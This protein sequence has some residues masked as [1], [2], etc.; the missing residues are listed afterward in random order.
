MG[1]ERLTDEPRTQI[2][3]TDA[4]VDHIGKALVRIAR[5]RATMDALNQRS[6]PGKCFL[7]FF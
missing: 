7:Y 6:H 3:A 4:K 5:R 2:R 1:V